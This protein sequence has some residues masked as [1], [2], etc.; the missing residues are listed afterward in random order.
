MQELGQD[1]NLQA[2]ID[3]EAMEGLLLGL[4][5]MDCSA[6]FLMHPRVIFQR[7]VLPTIEELQIKKAGWII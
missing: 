4:L 1:R 3:A 6:Y 7:V 2:G 5:L